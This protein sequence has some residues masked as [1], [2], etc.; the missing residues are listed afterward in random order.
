MLARHDDD[1]DGQSQ[2]SYIQEITVHQQLQVSHAPAAYTHLLR[3]TTVFNTPLITE[4]R[5]GT[6]SCI[7]TI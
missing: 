2:K 3:N 6:A 7:N 4:M 5:P 1:D